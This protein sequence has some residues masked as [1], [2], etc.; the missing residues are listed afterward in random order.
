[1][2]LNVLYLIPK[3]CTS[4]VLAILQSRNNQRNLDAKRLEEDL[5]S[6][7]EYFK[8]LLKTHRTTTQILNYG[9]NQCQNLCVL[10]LSPLQKRTHLYL[11]C[12]P[13]YNFLNGRT[14]IMEAVDIMD[15]K[16]MGAG[17]VNYKVTH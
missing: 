2:I 3:N 8:V 17:T 14:R 10:T 6:T 9:R 13:Q 16:E 1:M 15:A 11:F 4:L 5:T 7:P 12:F